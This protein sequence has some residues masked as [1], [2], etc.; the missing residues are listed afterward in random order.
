M[1]VLIVNNEVDCAPLGLSV[2]DGAPFRR[3]L[4]YAND[5]RAFS[6]FGLLVSGSHIVILLDISYGFLL[7]IFVKL[8]FLGIPYSYFVRYFCI[9]IFIRY[10]H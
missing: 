8:F 1:L 3:A 6:P 4:P 7:D 5:L 9:V 2:G 10:I